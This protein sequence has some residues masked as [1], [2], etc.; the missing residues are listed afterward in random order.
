MIFKGPFQAKSFF[1][2]VVVQSCDCPG[3]HCCSFSFILFVVSSACLILPGT[4]YSRT[5]PSET[6]ICVWFIF[7]I[8]FIFVC[9]ALWYVS[10]FWLKVAW[11]QPWFLKEALCF[12]QEL[13]IFLYVSQRKDNSCMLQVQ[14]DL[15]KSTMSCGSAGEQNFSPFSFF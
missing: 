9:F 10:V 7:L 11:F 3:D 15:I 8:I 4:L 12:L 5:L 14:W 1:S 6:L 13:C 2:S